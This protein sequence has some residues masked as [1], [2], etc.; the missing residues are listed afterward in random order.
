MPVAPV[1]DKGTQLYYVDTGPLEGKYLTVVL[2]HGT[3]I[4]GAIFHRMIPFAAAN[5]LR[6]VVVNRRDYPGSTR[7]TDEDLAALASP[8][9]ETRAEYFRQRALEFGEFLAWYV[10]QEKIPPY[11]VADDG[12]E[13]GGIVLLGWSSATTSLLSLLAWPERV[14]EKT[15]RVLEPYFRAFCEY[16]T[17]RWS[18]GFP[19]PPGFY[20]PLRDESLDPVARAVVFQS[21][22]S[23]YYA[24]PDI[25]SGDLATLTQERLQEPRPSMDTMKPEEKDGAS[26]KDATVRSETLVLT[27]SP[28]TYNA[29]IDRALDK[30]TAHLWPRC[31]IKMLWCEQSFWEVMS[32]KWEVDK[33]YA[34]KKAEGRVGREWITVSRP[35]ANHFLHWD[36]PEEFCKWLASAL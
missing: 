6:L 24:H 4:H 20:H 5:G 13:E 32:G 17:P 22:V 34:A 1:D 12:K 8:E 19:N 23:G 35:G 2:V 21:W 18:F 15:Q 7:L 10:Q 25:T 29:Q 28:P 33:L 3:A 16:D 30:S 11:T 27:M 14:P 26:Q 36:S 31:K 9:D